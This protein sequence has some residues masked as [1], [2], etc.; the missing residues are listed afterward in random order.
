MTLVRRRSAMASSSRP[1]SP[2]KISSLCCPSVGG[3]R[4]TEQAVAENLNG[5]PSIFKAP[6]AG[7]SMVST[8]PRAVAG[9]ACIL[10]PFGM[11]QHLGDARELALVSYPQRDHG[12]GGLIGRIRHDAGMAVAEAA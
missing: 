9:E 8:V 3:G 10:G 2:D 6:A 4:R 5:I 1:R 11:A 7:C 12:I